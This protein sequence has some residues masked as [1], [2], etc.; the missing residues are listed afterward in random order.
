MFMKKLYYYIPLLVGALLYACTDDV[1]TIKGF[2]AD[3]SNIEAEAVGGEYFVTIRS[4]EDWVAV[5]NEPWVMV[6][7]ANG[8]GETRCSIKIDSALMDDARNTTINISSGFEES[9]SIAITQK[10]FEK[11]ITP[12]KSSIDIAASAIKADRWVE[13]DVTTNVKFKIKSGVN[14]IEVDDDYELNLDRGMRPR[15]TRI[16]L[17]W[18]MN[19]DPKE[20]IE[21]LRFIS[22][23]AD[24]LELATLNIRQAAG[25]LIEDNRAGDSLAVIT[26]FEKLECWGDN[27]I[28]S[29]ESM[30]RWDCVRLWKSTDKSLPAPEAVGRVRDLD[31]SYFNTEDG[32]PVEIKHLKYLETLSLF[33]NVNTMLKSI[34]LGE[35]V[36]T[37]EYLKDLRI[38]AFGLVSLPDN[39]TNLVNLESLDLNSNNFNEIPAV[40]TKENFPKLKRLNLASNR[41]SS[42]TDL[43]KRATANED[44]IGI[45]TDMD[46][47]DVVKNL[48]LWEELE[49]LQ[50]SYNYIE[51]ALPDFEQMPT[52]TAEDVKE[53]GDTVNWAVENR[54]PR[55]LPNMRSLK[56][57]LNFMSGEV[58]DWLLY[59]PR[60]LE[61]GPEVLIFP[62]QEK[63]VD[64][65][66]KSVGFDNAPANFEYYFEK[67][68]LYR[69]RYEFNE[70]TEE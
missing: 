48:F 63:A 56:I 17:D 26:I 11:T 20:R 27:G 9:K 36:A 5:V 58:P 67:Y 52:Y 37:L 46:K 15:T 50:L 34:D 30:N 44:G 7:P 35:E 64:S 40:I 70:E 23:D 18:K 47:S 8:R 25:P 65:D 61:W 32:V 38:A 66:G 42:I 57:N 16:R 24:T 69:G 2:E 31:L 68:P 13:F 41:R 39:F 28:S 51:G 1:P 54:L 53:F 43:R 6:S 33:G 59:H 49:E 21:T 22:D 29:T 10:G 3:V 45:Y 60:L 62:Q 14:W 19:S 12:E 4:A 55:I